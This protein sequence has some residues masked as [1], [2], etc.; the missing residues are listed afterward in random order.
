MWNMF[1]HRQSKGSLPLVEQH[2]AAFPFQSSSGHNYDLWPWVYPSQT[3]QYTYFNSFYGNQ[4]PNFSVVIPKYATSSPAA[5]LNRPWVTS[6]NVQQQ[7]ALQ[8]QISGAAPLQFGQQQVADYIASLGQR[9]AAGGRGAWR[10]S[11]RPRR[12]NPA[13][14]FYQGGDLTNG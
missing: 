3:N 9:W 6:T 11:T 4:M 1:K 8:N 2:N 5:Q 10:R 7:N 12:V 14:T 13:H